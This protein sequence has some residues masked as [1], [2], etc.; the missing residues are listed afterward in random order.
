[1]NQGALRAG[2]PSLTGK[3]RDF[4][5]SLVCFISKKAFHA[6][7]GHEP[8]AYGRQS[9]QFDQS[10]VWVVPSPSGRVSARR[11]FNGRTRLDWF[12]HLAQSV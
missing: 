5:P 3:V 12:R 7:F 8:G 11:L 6:H 4:A 1:L 9:V 2:T 10:E